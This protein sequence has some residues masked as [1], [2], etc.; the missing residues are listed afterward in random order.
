[1]ESPFEQFPNTSAK[2]EQKDVRPEST[3][4][5]QSDEYF[6][7][8]EQEVI[9]FLTDGI[10]SEVN[11]RLAEDPT[12]RARGRNYELSKIPEEYEVIAF[13][14][15]KLQLIEE[16]LDEVLVENNQTEPGTAEEATS[17]FAAQLLARVKQAQEGKITS[18]A[19]LLGLE[20]QHTDVARALETGEGEQWT[21][22]M[23]QA[24]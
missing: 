23:S 1:M 15:K 22:M 12:F 3:E 8:A 6:E 5:R 13:M 17:Y 19:R 11:E 14:Q 24:A 21:P 2:N 9:N 10:E 20:I 7:R 4:R 18:T 16:H